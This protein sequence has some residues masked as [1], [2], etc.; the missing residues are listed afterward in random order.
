MYNELYS[1]TKLFSVLPCK[2]Q[3][4]VGFR[5]LIR[6]DDV[7]TIPKLYS[8]D[9]LLTLCTPFNWEGY[10]SLHLSCTVKIVCLPSVHSL[11]RMKLSLSSKMTVPGSRHLPTKRH[12]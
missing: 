7:A 11:T 12:H 2:V 1:T 10:M 8:T 9:F 4:F 5:T 3:F 6:H